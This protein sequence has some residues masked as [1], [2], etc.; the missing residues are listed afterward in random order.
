VPDEVIAFV[1]P[2]GVVTT[3]TGQPDL[4]VLHG[5]DGRF[6]PPVRFVGERVPG[7]DG[8]RL[9]DVT[10]GVRDVGLPIEVRKD[11]AADLRTRIRQLLPTLDPK[12]GEGK[13]RVT[14]PD[15]S[16][17]E[18]LCRYA[19]GFE[20]TE[21]DQMSGLHFQRA[22]LVFRAFD[23]L[24]Y[25]VNYTSQ[26]FTGSGSSA[27]FFPFFPLRLSS[28]EVFA[29]VVI[30]N[31]GDAE[32]YPEWLAE[33]PL[34]ALIL[35]NLTT[36]KLFELNVT[37]AAGETVAIDTRPGQ[38]TVTKQNGTNLFSSLTTASSLW[39]LARGSNSVRI[40]MGGS[41]AGSKVTLSHKQ[42]YLAA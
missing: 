33:G 26:Q 37:L 21:D 20:G 34:T 9:R 31:T 32:A 30:S 16:Q 35:R 17:R 22:L 25:D 5:V 38:K 13:L 2:D 12:E 23:P 39:S 10:L 18:L 6:M 29:D 27:T 40:E 14:A 28:S 24:W 42:R 3:L 36:G 15:S 7:A 1:D 11:T 4:E 8:E 41:G 19:G